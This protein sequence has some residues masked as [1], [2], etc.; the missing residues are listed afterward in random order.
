M[1]GEDRADACLEELGVLI[2][3]GQWPSADVV[4]A[5]QR[6]Q[7]RQ[8]QPGGNQRRE[9]HYA[10]VLARSGNVSRAA[11]CIIE[12]ELGQCK[13]FG[14]RARPRQLMDKNNVACQMTTC[15]LDDVAVM[16]EEQD[17]GPP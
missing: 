2:R 6:G 13:L 8:V 1:L 15:Q 5:G 9:S 3:D 4:I 12:L 14:L 17:L 16:R 11:G 7:S 10:M